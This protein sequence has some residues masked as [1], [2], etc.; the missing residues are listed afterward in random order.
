[1]DTIGQ[2]PP[3]RSGFAIE[4]W[5]ADAFLDD[6]SLLIVTLGRLRL[7][8]VQF[9]RLSVELH[10]PGGGRI[11][12]SGGL[13]PGRWAGSVLRYRFAELGPRQLRWN[14]PGCGGSLAF[15][16]RYPCFTPRDPVLQRGRRRLRWI[17]ECPDGEV[18]GELLLPSGRVAV[19]GRGYRDY[20][21]LDL[22]PWALRGCELRWGRSVS[23]ETAQVWFRL[24]TPA[25]TVTAT[26]LNGVVQH[27]GPLPMLAQERVLS[28][29]PLADLP[30]MRIGPVRWLLSHLAGRPELVRKTA[31]SVSGMPCR[32]V[33][34][35]VTWR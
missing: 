28:E 9:D 16:S 12:A 25:D 7:L 18:Q 24:A 19:R 34:E 33:D 32:A 15:T 4:K 35:L 17:V 1:M 27:D 31:A 8:G 5:Y 2:R 21:V 11:V 22:L 30:L 6:G 23:H 26:W 13:G 14:L 29:A 20:V 3:L 10:R